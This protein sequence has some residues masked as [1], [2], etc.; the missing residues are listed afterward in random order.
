MPGRY[1]GLRLKLTACRQFPNCPFPFGQARAILP[2]LVEFLKRGGSLANVLESFDTVMED[3]GTRFAFPPLGSPRIFGG[4]I[5][6]LVNGFR[7]GNGKTVT[8][9]ALVGE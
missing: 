3:Q 8:F 4:N 1:G 6:E 7:K 5:R 2:A 9:R